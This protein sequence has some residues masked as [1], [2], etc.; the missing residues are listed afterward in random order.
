MFLE[1]FFQVVSLFGAFACQGLNVLPLLAD[2][3]AGLISPSCSPSISNLITLTATSTSTRFL[4][5]TGFAAMFFTVT[6]TLAIGTFASHLNITWSL[7]ANLMTFSSITLYITK[8]QG[9][10]TDK[11]LVYPMGFGGK[12]QVT[13]PY[14][15][16]TTAD[17]W[18]SVLGP[19]SL[20]VNVSSSQIL[21]K[22]S[23]ITY[24][25]PL[26]LIAGSN[27]SSSVTAYVSGGLL[28]SWA[29]ITVNGTQYM[30]D[31]PTAASTQASCIDDVHWP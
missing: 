9:P 4:S 29:N 28:T 11:W 15:N 7:P 8:S 27:M 30:M 6:D 18:F 13:I 31:I 22:Y 16:I 25:A 10:W 23:G 3:V 12:T 2:D 19:T 26:F 20:Q 14:L 5:S 24:S 1:V 17:C 21:P